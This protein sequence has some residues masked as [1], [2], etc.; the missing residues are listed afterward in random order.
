MM[1]DNK[2]QAG[3]LSGTLAIVTG[4]ASGIGRAVCFALQRQGAGIMV[5]DL[6]REKIDE[7]VASLHSERSQG[8]AEAMGIPCNVQSETDMEKMAETALQHFGCV[9]LLVHCAGIL[10]APGSG[11]N[12]LHQMSLEEYDAVIDTNLKGTFL[13]NRAVLP[14]MMKQGSGHIIN[15][16]STSGKKGR[17]FDSVYCASKFGVLGLSEALAEEVRQYGIKVHVVLPDAVDTPIWDQNG[18]VKAPKNSLPAERIAD[19]TA[20]L[21]CLPE[22]TVLDNLVIMPFKVRRRKK[23]KKDT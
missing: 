19:L 7:V 2:N 17:A 13:A 6:S 18:P 21:A 10:R 3:P 8:G 22:D 4:G 16:S 12:F 11:P 9:D 15:F 1:T 23:K 5:V 20:Y 14:A